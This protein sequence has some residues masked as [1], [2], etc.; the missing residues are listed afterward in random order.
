MISTENRCITTQVKAF[1]P[2]DIVCLVDMYDTFSPKGKFQ[3]LPPEDK[4][5]RMSWI[6]QMIEEGDNFLAWR[7]GGVIGHAVI[8]PNTQK[9]NAEYIIFVEQRSRGIGVGTMLTRASIEKAE[10]IGMNL[11][12]LTVD[13]YNMRA[14]RFYKKCGFRFYDN[15]ESQTEHMMIYRFR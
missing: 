1:I 9:K 15:Y 11:L 3:G 10:E 7:D 5:A 6:N 2:S 14:K 13:A 8:L 4:I 12:W